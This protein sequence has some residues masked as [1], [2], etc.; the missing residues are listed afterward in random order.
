MYELKGIT[1]SIN[2]I[3]GIYWNNTNNG[4][5]LLWKVAISDIHNYDC[6]IS[7]AIF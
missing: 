5:R 7:Y 3:F 2:H 6:V 4:N 1:I